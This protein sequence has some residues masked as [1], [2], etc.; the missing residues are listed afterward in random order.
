ML[1]RLGLFACLTLLCACGSSDETTETSEE[2]LQPGDLIITEVM[3]DSAA[4]TNDDW[5]EIR[6]VT[7]RTICVA[8]LRMRANL[9]ESGT[10]TVPG[11][12]E[13]CIAA[14][15]FYVF[16]AQEH[17]YVHHVNAKIKLPAT[18]QDVLLL[19]GAQLIDSA[20]YSATDLT[21]PLGKPAD[22]KSFSL[23]S[24]CQ[25]AMC[26]KDTAHWIIEDKEKYND[27][28]YGTPG[29]ATTC[30]TMH[31]DTF[32]SDIVQNCVAPEAGDLVITEVT[33]NPFDEDI[34]E[35]FEIYVTASGAGKHLNGIDVV[36]D[37]KSRGIIDGNACIPLV[38]ESYLTVAGTEFPFG[39][40]Q[41]AADVVLPSLKVPNKEAVMALFAGDMLLDE[42]TYDEKSD[43][44]SW[45]L[46][47][48]YL[49]S[50][51]NDSILNWCFTSTEDTTA[52][53]HG[54]GDVSYATPGAA[55]EV[56]PLVCG[57][58]QCIAGDF[59]IP[60]FPVVAGDVTVT[61][62]MANPHDEATGEWFEV[63]FTQNV[64]GKHLNGLSIF[65]DGT[66][67]GELE[68]A[69]GMCIVASAN[70]YLAIAKS[71]SFLADQGIENVVEVSKLGL[72]NDSV[73]LSLKN[74]DEV[75]V[76]STYDEKSDGISYQLNIYEIDA[77]DAAEN[78]CYTPATEEFLFAGDEGKG[79]YGTPGQPNTGCP[80]ICK[81][82]ECELDGMCSKIATVPLGSLVIT[83]VMSD[84]GGG[85]GEWFEVLVTAEADGKH[86]NGLEVFVDNSSKGIVS[87]ES[88]KCLVASG[89]DRLVVG[90]KLDIFA[91]PYPVK[92]NLLVPSLALK[93]GE[94]ELRLEAGGSKIDAATYD[95]KVSGVS[96]QLSGLFNDA[97]ANDSTTNW[98]FTPD[99][100]DFEVE[101]GSYGSPGEA[102]PE[103]P[104]E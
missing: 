38:P 67:K 73:E 13:D 93:N 51:S 33:A 48:A 24:Y 16:G 74:G 80:L 64:K 17:D 69:A 36:V 34:G 45:Q 20:R 91:T 104:T 61:E 90:K 102:N 50:E 68:G 97:V 39:A 70:E 76:A 49:D 6:N 10:F 19:K 42:A 40:D 75:I 22:G 60:I 101:S 89:G 28:D 92:A 26:S 72:K 96:Y 83:E 44:I 32:D 21:A 18:K 11:T 30:S 8:G 79:S 66:Q 103:C 4:D 43:G 14:G 25:D 3:V 55:N 65:V 1:R 71:A 59:C 99:T 5:V 95:N 2:T 54:N 88:N 82:D 52:L 58:G 53:P 29:S 23:C 12:V 86:L 27:A 47:G 57:D 87:N 35:W 7:N 41:V 31:G 85:K 84:P 62:V 9:H 37:G 78:W 77:P 98:C 46:S 63:R 100:P 56:C 94:F 81:D 15:D